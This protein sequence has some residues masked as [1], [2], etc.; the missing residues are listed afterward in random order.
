MPNRKLKV[1]PQPEK[2]TRAVLHFD[3]K[4]TSIII[5]GKG[6]LDLLCGSCGATLAKGVNEGQVKN[7]VLLCNKCGSYNDTL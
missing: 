2:G 7:L 4:D 6:N 1:I 3:S 5:Q